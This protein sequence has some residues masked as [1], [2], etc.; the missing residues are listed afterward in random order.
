MSQS[1]AKNSWTSALYGS[2]FPEKL[3]LPLEV[4]ELLTGLYP[5]ID[6]SKVHFFSNM[7]WFM[8]HGFAIGITLPGTYNFR[9]INIY[10]KEF[11]PYSESGL[12][13]LVH[14][15]FH[16]LQYRDLNRA[17]GLGFLR[18]FMVYYLADFF[19]LFF[20]NLFTEGWSSASYK[21]YECHPMELP[22]YALEYEFRYCYK[23][24]GRAAMI[25]AP[26]D[27]CIRTTSNYSYEGNL[28]FVILGFV[29]TFIFML[30]K[31]IFELILLLLV[32]FTKIVEV[33]AGLVNRK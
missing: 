25:E 27:S 12:A 11:D 19:R 16:A 17:Y 1:M 2:V 8:V 9:G 33:G 20:Q 21:A 18:S 13:L 15:V 7:P 26:P 28:I 29:V 4:R 31:P 23:T 32:P 5:T 30:V 10:L 3:E 14:E 24:F 22:A 6:F